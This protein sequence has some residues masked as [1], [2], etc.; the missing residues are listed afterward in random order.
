[1]KNIKINWKSFIINFS[2]S[3]ISTIIADFGIGCYYS[4]GLGSD[5]VSVFI[6]GLHSYCGLSYGTISTICNV[7]L[8]VCIF[9]FERK[10][11]GVGTIAAMCISGTFI[12]IFETLLR[13]NFPVATTSLYIRIVILIIG[14]ITFAIGC[15]LGI[16]CHLGIGCFQFPPIF[17]ADITK[18]NLTYTQMITDATFFIIGWLL[19]GV[20]GI[21]TIAG[22]LLTGPILTKSIELYEKWAEKLGP[23][24]VKN[25]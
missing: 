2:V 16:A 14:V 23:A 15:G 10:H 12:D 3:I 6:D 22:V 20:I 13:T 7:I 24:F 17:L 1:M 5:P 18:I 8:T 9:L 19:G 4:C 11:I 21:G 25:N